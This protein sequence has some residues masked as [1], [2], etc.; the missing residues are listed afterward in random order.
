MLKPI[1]FEINFDK[2]LE[3]NEQVNIVASM[4]QPML[5]LSWW[6]VE[7]PQCPKR[8]KM[9]HSELMAAARTLVIRGHE[10]T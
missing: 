5:S 9:R 8:L 6:E 4:A 1:I 10:E 2:M 7:V 3:I